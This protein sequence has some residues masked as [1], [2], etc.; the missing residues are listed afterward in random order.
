[1]GEEPPACWCVYSILMVICHEEGVDIQDHVVRLANCMAPI[2]SY[3][4]I[5]ALVC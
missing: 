2:N 4:P 3:T 1:M 5:Y